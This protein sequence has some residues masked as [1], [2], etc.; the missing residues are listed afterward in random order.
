[1]MAPD[2]RRCS[3]AGNMDNVNSNLLADEI[4]KIMLD[5]KDTTR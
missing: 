2:R 1:L 3:R 5:L 4:L